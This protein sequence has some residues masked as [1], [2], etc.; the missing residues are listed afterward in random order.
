[1][2]KHQAPSWTGPIAMMFPKVLELPLDP[3]FTVIDGG[4]LPDLSDEEIRDLSTDQKNLYRL[5]NS[6]NYQ[7]RNYSSRL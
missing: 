2:E 4:D 6:P 1:M 7:D 5:Q 3:D